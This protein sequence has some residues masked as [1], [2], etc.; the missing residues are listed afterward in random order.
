MSHLKLLQKAFNKFAPWGLAALLLGIGIGVAGNLRP[1]AQASTPYDSLRTFAEV[2]SLIQNNYVEEKS[3]DE[4]TTAAIKGLLKKLDPHSSFMDAK[5]YKARRQETEGHFGGLGI[6]I[7][8]MDSF[9]TIVAPIEGTPAEKA[10][11]LPGDQ[12]IKISGKSTKDMTLHEAVGLMR[13]KVGAPITITIYRVATDETFDVTIIRAMIKIQSVKY[14]MIDDEVAYV[15]ISTFS[16]NTARD[17]RKAIEYL[18]DK[19]FKRLILDMRNNPGGL[20]KQAVDVTDLFIDKGHT[21]VSTR[22]RTPDQ[23]RKFLSNRWGIGFDFPMVVLINAASASAAEIVAGAMKDLHRA[24]IVGVRSFGKGS[25]QTV[26]QLSDGS[27]LS[28][29]TARYYTPAG[30]MIHGTGIEPD[31]EVKYAL[32]TEN[33]ETLEM[34]APF[35]EKD[36]MEGFAGTSTSPLSEE[37]KKQRK[38]IRETLQKRAKTRMKHPREIFNLKEDNQLAKALDIVKTIGK[39]QIATSL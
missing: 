1:V 13:G 20:L 38:K 28:L 34:P 35:R 8:V 26:R 4:L 37:Q 33:G 16:Q 14:A 12:V 39:P 19:N 3:T 32:K 15:R 23:N 11:L 27:G 24:T 21:I 5:A 30:I 6:E 7:T 9:I 17:L 22:G 18:Q 2:L 31:I 25:V 36:L 29:T 10:G